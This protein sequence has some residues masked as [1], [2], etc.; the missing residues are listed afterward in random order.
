MQTIYTD[1]NERSTSRETN[2]V[3][4][5]ICTGRSSRHVKGECIR[6]LGRRTIGI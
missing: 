6:R 5:V 1:E 3:G 2:P 4:V